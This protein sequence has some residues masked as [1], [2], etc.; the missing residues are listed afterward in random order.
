MIVCDWQN[1]AAPSVLKAALARPIHV[2]AD[3]PAGLPGPLLSVTG[4]LAMPIRGV[5][6]D[7]VRRARDLLVRGE[8]VAAIGAGDIGYVLATT[9]VPV[10][11]VTVEAPNTK[12]PTDPP[13]RKSEMTLTLSDVHQFPDRLRTQVPTRNGA[14]AAAEWARQILVDARVPV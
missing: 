12:R 14:R 2:W 4:D 1:I 8:V 3:G 10:L 7:V 9:Q 6:L 11:A 5:G 13:A